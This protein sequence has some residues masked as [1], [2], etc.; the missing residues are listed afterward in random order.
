MRRFGFVAAV[1]AL[2]LGGCQYQRQLRADIEQAA[3]A[4]SELSRPPFLAR[5][6]RA[7]AALPKRV[8]KRPQWLMQRVEAVYKDMPA[9]SALRALMPPGHRVSFDA[10]IDIEAAASVDSPPPGSSLLQHLDGIAAQLNWSWRPDG[11]KNLIWTAMPS[12]VFRIAI[13]AGK[14]SAALGR[15]GGGVSGGDGGGGGAQSTRLEQ[16]TQPWQELEV[17]LKAHLGEYKFSLLPS[18]N[19]VLVTAPPDKL[20]DVAKLIERFNRTATQRVLVEMEI[21]LVDLSESKQQ[22]LDWSFI[23]DG[24]NVFGKSGPPPASNLT[25]FIISLNR[26]S[27]GRYKGSR[28]IL[29]ALEEQGATSVVTRPRLI[30]LNNQVSEL[31]LNRVTPYTQNVQYRERSSGSTTRVFPEVDTAE[32]ISGTTIYVA[33]TISGE[34]IT[35]TLSANYRQLTRFFEESVGGTDAG[36]SAVNIKLPEYDDTQFT[37]PI[38][39]RSGETMVLAG[40]PRTMKETS[41][42]RNPLLPFLPWFGAD[43]TKRR[44][45]TVLLVSA[46]LLDP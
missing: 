30:C 35:L 31:R 9:S 33:P 41:S 40:N 7:T 11:D 23:R 39:L 26:I 43:G 16:T 21:Y 6:N 34:R 4:V 20:R 25:P 13:G 10:S 42:N 44:L 28:A 5:A 24:N 12:R 38:S 29:N 17:A 46:H 19:S 3:A 36:A 37:L 18:I 8:I 1:V 15:Q 14:R 27:D 32:L 45:E 22:S 2:A